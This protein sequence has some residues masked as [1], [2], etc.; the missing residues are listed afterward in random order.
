MMYHINMRPG[1]HCLCVPL[2][3]LLY[4]EHYRYNNLKKHPNIF[5][6]GYDLAD[7]P[8]SI[9]KFGRWGRIARGHDTLFPM[10]HHLFVKRSWL[11]FILVTQHPN[12]H[13]CTL[14]L[15]LFIK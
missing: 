3:L 12:T 8:K 5:V 1:Y 2:K 7:I 14:L 11:L 13:A 10:L 9:V 4:A 15:L 6:N